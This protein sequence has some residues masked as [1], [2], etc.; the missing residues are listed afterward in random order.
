M[1]AA[2]TALSLPSVTLQVRPWIPFYRHL[3][4][5]DRAK[6]CWMCGAVGALTKGYHSFQIVEQVSCFKKPKWL[7]TEKEACITTWNNCMHKI[8]QKWKWRGLLGA[9]AQWQWHVYT[10]EKE[11]RKHITS[12]GNSAKCCPLN[13]PMTMALR[14]VAG[15]GY[16][17]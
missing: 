16:F 15:T 9:C 13:I 12:G 3:F 14:K 8:I 1:V 11:K 17:G 6:P 5:S 7:Q 2:S 10:W 4:V